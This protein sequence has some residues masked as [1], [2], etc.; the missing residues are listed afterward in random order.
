MRF[1]VHI[2]SQVDQFRQQFGMPDSVTA[3]IGE[4]RPNIR[5]QVVGWCVVRGLAEAIP[6]Q[7]AGLLPHRPRLADQHLG[8]RT[9]HV[10]RAGDLRV[11]FLT[12]QPADTQVAAGKYRGLDPVPMCRSAQDLVI[13]LMPHHLEAKPQNRVSADPGRQ[14]L[15]VRSVAKTK[16]S[17][18]AA[19][20]TG[21]MIQ[22]H[23]GIGYTWEHEAHF[24]YKRAK[25]LAGSY[26]TADDHR[27][28]I[29][30]LTAA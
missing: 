27:K 26:G 3:A 30:D 10:E 17:D 8:G 1:C 28:R 9:V 21:A 15:R 4:H 12:G 25:R 7:G 24:F 18:T 5:Q 29:A 13:R 6:G 20:V 22:Y 14:R 23:G 2:G 11:V 19:Q 16:A